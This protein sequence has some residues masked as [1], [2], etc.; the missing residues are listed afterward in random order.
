MLLST[1]FL[2]DIVKRMFCRLFLGSFIIRNLRRILI[3]ADAPE[4]AEGFVESLGRDD[5]L[6]YII[7][8]RHT[9]NRSNLPEEELAEVRRLLDRVEVDEVFLVLHS[10]GG[11]EVHRLMLQWCQS[12]GV[13]VRCAT[14]LEL[15]QW[16]WSSVDRLPG[17]QT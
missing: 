9:I 15:L 16:S 6:G 10:T 2:A 8:A 5:D 11:N 7:E 12:E 17:G 13:T 14:N 1:P 4:A 3:V